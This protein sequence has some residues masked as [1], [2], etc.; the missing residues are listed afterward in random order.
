MAQTELN[1]VALL[2]HNS[3]TPTTI[4]IPKYRHGIWQTGKEGCVGINSTSNPRKGEVHSDRLLLCPG[5]GGGFATFKGCTTQSV[6]V[7]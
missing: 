5:S 6:E 7:I 2:A 3:T 4:L 1:M